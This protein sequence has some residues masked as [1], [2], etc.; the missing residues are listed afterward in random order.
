MIAGSA[1]LLVVAFAL[2]M[3]FL[4]PAQNMP[5][6]FKRL[7]FFPLG[8][9]VTFGYSFSLFLFFHLRKEELYIFYHRGIK[10][11]HC[12]AFSYV[13]QWVVAGV[14]CLLICVLLPGKA[15]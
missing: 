1:T 3:S 2:V 4:L 7:L 9:L 14:L 10:P 5:L 13:L 8:L 12:I 15:V 11:W 6:L